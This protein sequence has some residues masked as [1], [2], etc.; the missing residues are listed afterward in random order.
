MGSLIP[1]GGGADAEIKMRLN[2]AFNDSNIA[3]V[4]SVFANEKLFD[5]RHR[6]HRLAYRLGTYP[7]KTYV[8]D[9]AKGKW[10]YFLKKLLKNAAHN[11]VST[12]EVDR[13]I[14]LIRNANFR[15]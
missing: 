1:I 12:A 8:G 4:R 3:I 10:F 15:C 14:S 7:T 11:G 5:G 6:L 2:T 13:Q 9:D